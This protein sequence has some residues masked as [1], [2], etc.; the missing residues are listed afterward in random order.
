M[1]QRVNKFVAI[2]LT[3]ASTNSDHPVVKRAALTQ[4]DIFHRCNLTVEAGV[5][6][7]PNAAGHE[8]YD[9]CIFDFINRGG[10]KV[11]EHT[12]NALGIMLVHL[13]AE[14]VDAESHAHKRIHHDTPPIS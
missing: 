3:N 9:I 14:S 10:T 1:R 2:A 6:R 7:L 4:R 8:H 11:F 13:A 12:Y 5:C